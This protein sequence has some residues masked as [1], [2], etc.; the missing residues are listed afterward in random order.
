MNS[1]VR[2]LAPCLG[3]TV[4]V[5]AAALAWMSESAAEGRLRSTQGGVPRPVDVRWVAMPAPAKQALMQESSRRVA[6]D[7]NL[8]AH[9]GPTQAAASG[10]APAGLEA[11]ADR[12]VPAA[13]PI[14]VP[15]TVDHEANY[16][17]RPLLSVVPTPIS[18]VE[19]S[20]PDVPEDPGH[21]IGELALF[22]DETGVVRRVRFEGKPLPVALEDAAR[23]AFVGARFTPGELDGASVRSLIRV[24]V[25][26]DRMPGH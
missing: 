8:G 24:E 4:L 11:S 19:I 5:H 17:P 22:I 6:V 14:E 7:T 16:L 21:H 12:P 1:L 9:R 13:L 26:F 15:A 23:E 10:Q 25:R 18:T 3:L 2:H 20:Y